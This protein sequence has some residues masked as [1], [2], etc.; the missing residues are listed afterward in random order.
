MGGER[1]RCIREVSEKEFDWAVDFFDE[2]WHY[3]RIDFNVYAYIDDQ[4]KLVA[5]SKA[6][7]YFLVA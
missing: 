4:G 1:M 2:T 3:V 5:F 7:R 6:W